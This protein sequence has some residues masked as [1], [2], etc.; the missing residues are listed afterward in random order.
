MGVFGGGGH[1]IRVSN[2]RQ[3]KQRK[4]LI[5]S[6]HYELQGSVAL[7]R[8]FRKPVLTSEHGGAAL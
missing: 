6:Q 7:R 5:A 2:F 3:F 8:Q 1:S 4:A